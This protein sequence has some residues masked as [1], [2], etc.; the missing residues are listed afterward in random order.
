M[1]NQSMPTRLETL[2]NYHGLNLVLTWYW[3]VPVFSARKKKQACTLP[4]VQKMLLFLL[5]QKAT[6]V[7]TI[8]L[9]VNDD[10]LDRRTMYSLML[11]VLPTAWLR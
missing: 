4:L 9:G 8:V 5:L 3:N 11:L 10:E 6:D 1:A 2:K 7:Q